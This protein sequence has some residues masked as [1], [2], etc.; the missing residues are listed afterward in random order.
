MLEIAHGGKLGQGAERDSPQDKNAALSCAVQ[1]E[2]QQPNGARPYIA[3]CM[4]SPKRI[5]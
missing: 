5:G 4:A 1:L 3:V 2:G